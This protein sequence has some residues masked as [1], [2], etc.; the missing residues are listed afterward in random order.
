ME[1]LGDQTGGTP[2]VVKQRVRKLMK[3]EGIRGVGSNQEGAEWKAPGERKEEEPGQAQGQS[4]MKLDFTK[5]ELRRSYRNGKQG[6]LVRT[7]PHH[8]P[9]T[10]RRGPP[11]GRLPHWRSLTPSAAH[12]TLVAESLV[13]GRGTGGWSVLTDSGS[14]VCI[15]LP[16]R[17]TISGWAAKLPPSEVTD[18]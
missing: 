13:C 9:V 10:S 12:W 14:R 7:S 17:P 5:L 16:P 3:G 11:R 1:G 15:S 8:S 2:P 6:G 18:G 4:S